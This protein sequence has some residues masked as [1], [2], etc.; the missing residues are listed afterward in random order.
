MT[1]TIEGT[2]AEKVL[3]EA[4]CLPGSKHAPRAFKPIVFA[5]LAV[6]PLM[7]ARLGRKEDNADLRAASANT[8][9]HA[10]IASTGNIRRVNLLDLEERVAIAQEETINA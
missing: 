6:T 3:T 10:T 7:M 2:V 1:A 5:T 4:Q 9:A 8:T